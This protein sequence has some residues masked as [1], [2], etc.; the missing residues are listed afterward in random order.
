MPHEPDHP[1]SDLPARRG[2][3][4]RLHLLAG[5]TASLAMDLFR[6][7]LSLGVRLL[8]L[9]DLGRVLL[10]RHSYVPGWHLPGGGVEPGETVRAAAMR[11]AREEGGID[12]AEPPEL[13]HVYAN[14]ALGRH[15]HVLLFLARG[16]AGPT[17]PP[18]S[19]LEIRETGFFAPGALPEETTS[20]TRNRIAEMLSASP[21]ADLW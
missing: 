13:F 18:A 10:V 12:L 19:R 1:S 9:D 21:P 7:R 17:R 4:T 11:E 16:V 3:L 8:A 2:A 6:P 20:A 14:R 15:D 5:Q